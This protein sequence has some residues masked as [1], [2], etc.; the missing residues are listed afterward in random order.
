M[1]PHVIKLIQKFYAAAVTVITILAGICLMVACL[2]IYLSGDEPYSREAVSAAFSS[3]ALVE[4]LCLGVV[5]LGFLLELILPKQKRSVQ[6]LLCHKRILSRLY[7]TKDLQQAPPHTAQQ[8]RQLQ[9]YERFWQAVTIATLGAGILAFMVYLLRADQFHLED[10]NGCV[11][12]ATAVLLICMSVPFACAITGHYRRVHIMKRQITLLKTLPAR[13]DPLTPHAK[14]A[15]PLLLPRLVFLTAAIVLLLY[16]FF[17]GGTADVLVKAINI[18]T[19]CV[20]L[21]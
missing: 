15:A 4:Y 5:I 7:G 12:R 13:T 8:I 11:L 14:A 9:S 20:G 3:I 19:E 6:V 17:T 16:G 18:C 10:I 2:G 1:T 21:G